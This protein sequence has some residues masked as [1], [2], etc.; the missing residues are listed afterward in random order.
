MFLCRTFNYPPIPAELIKNIQLGAVVRNYPGRECTL[1]GKT[2]TTSSGTYYY[3][4]Q[5]IDQWVR[6]HID[7]DIDFVG[8]RYQFGTTE[9]DSQGAH[10]DATRD[11]ALLYTIE[12][13]NGTLKFWQQQDCPI[14]Y[15]S[16]QLITDYDSLEEIGSFN[17]PNNQWYLVN[18]RVLHSVENITQTRITLQV[19]LKSL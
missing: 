14:E 10:T 15:D 17:I 5:K 18:G 4:D 8:I 7:C 6:N 13:A 1:N 9:F 19:N 12:N 16:V 2:F 11:Y 3:A